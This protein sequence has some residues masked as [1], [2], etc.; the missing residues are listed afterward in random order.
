MTV[1]ARQNG[2]PGNTVERVA[3]KLPYHKDA[4]ERITLG[5]LTL[6]DKLRKLENLQPDPI[7]G[8]L[9]NQLFDL[10]LSDPR[11]QAIIP[12]LRQLWGDAEYLLELDFARKVISGAPSIPECLRLYESFPYLDQYR[13][14]ARME[15]N[16]LDTAL[17]EKGLPPVRKVAFLGS[18][19][20]PFSALCFRE[21]LGPGV[22]IVNIDRSPEAIDHGQRMAL[23]LGPE[24]SGNMG[25]VRAEVAVA[26]A[27]TS[28]SSSS[29]GGNG[30]VPVSPATAADEALALPDLSDCDLVH[31]AALIGETERDKRDL[32]I[33][34]AKAMR[35]GS[36]IML[37]STDSL[38]QCLYP[39]MDVDC[40][41]V[42]DVVSPV[43]AT[44]YFGASTSLTTIVVSVDG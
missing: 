6:F 21:R 28:P 25:F 32:L 7:N 34:V 38:R 22:E 39:K 41:E 3:T 5:I 33:A 24:F 9:F 35:P 11:V 43:L 14:L 40:W 30:A 37:R 13:Q 18:G 15:T 31:F 2:Q 10:I 36:L 29:D 23:S 4:A 26:P 27:S 17:G 42:L 44:R 16:T 12:E 1:D 19:P 8:R 20:T